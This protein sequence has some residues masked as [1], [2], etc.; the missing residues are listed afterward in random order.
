[1]VK[2]LSELG[3]KIVVGSCLYKYLVIDSYKKEIDYSDLNLKEVGEIEV[4]IDKKYKT[5]IF[6]TEKY[7]ANLFFFSMKN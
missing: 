5:K 2:A 7:G 6:T 1:L 4:E 3:L